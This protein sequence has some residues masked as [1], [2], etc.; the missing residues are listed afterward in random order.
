VGTQLWWYTARA[1]G[2]VAWVLLA[3]GVLWGLALSTKMFG[4]RPRPAW[5]LDLH[6]ALGGLSVIFTG[7]HVAGVMLDSYVHFGLAE[8]L[9]PLASRWHPVAVAWGIVGFYLLL[10]VELTSLARRHLSK[11]VWRA[12]HF[13]SFP[14]F[15]VATVHGLSAGTDTKT[16]IAAALAAVVTAAVVWLTAVRVRA[17]ARTGPGAGPAPVR[18]RPRPRPTGPVEPATRLGDDRYV[19]VP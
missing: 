2:I 5:L 11:R 8:V 7:V 17:A 3:A 1:A 15:V 13:A 9:V 10:A 16:P 6:R 18:L 4:R 14:L 12:I 19:R